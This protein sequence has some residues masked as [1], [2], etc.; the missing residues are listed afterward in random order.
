MSTT[1]EETLL[2]IWSADGTATALVPATRF[3]VPGNWQN[4]TRPYVIQYPIV[5][6]SRQTHNGN[7]AIQKLRVWLFQFSVIGDSYSSAKAVAEQIRA[8]FAGNIS[9]VQFFYLGQRWVGMDE[10]IGTEHIA[11]EYRIAETLTT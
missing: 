3:K 2:S 1:I 6:T 8:T 4:L 10:I 9:G 11:V 5:E 7:G